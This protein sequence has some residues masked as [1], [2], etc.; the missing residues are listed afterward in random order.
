[1]NDRSAISQGSNREPEV[2]TNSWLACTYHLIHQALDIVRCR[3]T[4]V[5]IK[6]LLWPNSRVRID[7]CVLY[8]EDK[9]LAPEEVP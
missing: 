1:M 7:N 6:L 9:D 8:C 3:Q 4:V 2:L 5:T